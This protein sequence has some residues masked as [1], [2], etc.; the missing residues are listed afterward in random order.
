MICKDCNC[1]K[2]GYSQSDPDAYVCTGVKL[3]FIIDDVYAECTKYP[4]INK[5]DD[6]NA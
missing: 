6:D 3:P 4:K 2:K 5:G 1:C